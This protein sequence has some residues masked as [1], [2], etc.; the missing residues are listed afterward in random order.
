MNLSNHDAVAFLDI[1]HFG[2]CNKHH[3]DDQ[4]DDAL[5]RVVQ[6]IRQTA[7]RQDLV[8][9]KG[10]EEIVVLLSDASDDEARLAAERMR[11]AVE[12]AAIQH[13]ASPTAAVITITVGV[14]SS[15]HRGPTSVRQ[16]MHLAAKA[17]MEAKVLAQ[18]N[19]VHA[20]RGSVALDGSQGGRSRRIG[21]GCRRREPRIEDSLPR[22]STVGRKAMQ[23]MSMTKALVTKG[24]A[25]AAFAAALS[26]CTSPYK[27]PVLASNTGNSSFQGV[28]DM[29]DPQRPLDLLVV[30]GMCTHDDTWAHAAISNLH[31]ALGGTG[32]VDLVSVDVA[33]T[34][35][36]LLQQTL[37]TPRG[38]VRAN[39]ILWSPLTTPLKARLCYD[40]SEKSETCP[41]EEKAQAYP[42]QR[43]VLN[44]ILKDGIL[45]DCLSDAV[46]YQGRSRDQINERMQRAVLQAMA[47][48]GGKGSGGDMAAA[49]ASVDEN[50]PLV[51]VSESLGSKVAF[52]AIFKLAESKSPTQRAAGQRTFDRTTMI[53]MGANQVPILALGDALLDGS[54][55]SLA[56]DARAY[57]EDSLA[58]LLMARKARASLK[59]ASASS[60]A[61]LRVVAFSDPNDL[62]SYVLVPSPWAK[63]YDV[64][65]VVVSNASTFLGLLEMPTT[66]HQGYRENQAVRKFIACGNPTSA[67]CP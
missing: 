21:E 48:S 47:T 63:T 2:S 60:A 42:Y 5:R 35:I 19:R 8:F 44:R 23:P 64:V 20:A 28:V 52:D 27:T 67:R 30:H 11:A 38:P 24:L 59:A 3:G 25:I 65:D 61:P 37:S 34:G 22:R 13:F 57:P 62:L 1:D 12:R 10:G 43:A 49:A 55:K 4:G 46:I 39:A 16:L 29:L 58:E 40:Q 7:R 31:A 33:D 66:A 45:N 36:R 32:K 26:A 54:V 6:V 41:A 51:V 18:R 50:I 56:L 17:A 15:Q 9:R 53:F 14:A